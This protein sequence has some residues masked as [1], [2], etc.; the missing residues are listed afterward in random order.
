M[1]IAHTEQQ[2]VRDEFDLMVNP[3]ATMIE[4]MVF[5]K[6]EDEQLPEEAHSSNK[7]TSD[8]G[9][10]GG[11]PI[12]EDFD[13]QNSAM[14]SGTSSTK[15][16]EFNSILSSESADETMFRGFPSTAVAHVLQKGEEVILI[17]SD[18]DDSQVERKVE[19]SFM[20]NLINYRTSNQTV[21]FVDLTLSEN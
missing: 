11:S 7:S 18:T 2:P 4:S 16:R 3:F 8:S 10:S 5:S 13:L 19:K 9:Y 6:G 17:E 15:P 20:I 12:S 14:S 1:E 21:K